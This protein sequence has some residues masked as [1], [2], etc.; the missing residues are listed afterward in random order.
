MK[1]TEVP[2]YE[3]KLYVGGREGYHGKKFS[4]AKLQEEIKIHQR[5]AGKIS[6][7]IIECIFQIEGWDEEGWQIS[8]I[9]HYQKDK[10]YSKE[11]WYEFMRN[12]FNGL[13]IHICKELKQ[14]K[15][16]FCDGKITK[17]FEQEK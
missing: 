7:C 8:C 1:I 12:W 2:F 10:K 11:F 14:E 5:S 16:I 4:K 17:V 13:A 3:M 15:V 6:V 9:D